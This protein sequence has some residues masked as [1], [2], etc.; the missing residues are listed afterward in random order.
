MKKHLLL[1]LA[2][3]ALLATACKTKNTP[4][5]LK[6]DVP[7][8]P[9][10]QEN[11][12]GL[13]TEPLDTV[14]IGIVGLGMRGSGAV[15]RLTYVPG[16]VITALCDVVP[17]R[18]AK[19]QEI[20]ARRGQPAAKEYTGEEAAYQAL[21]QQEDL[22]LVYICTDWSHHVPVALCAM[23]NGKHADIEVPAAGTLED[24]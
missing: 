4:T 3:T 8:R 24:I 10:G 23:E 2:V 19:S 14:R 17:E 1:F 21:C 6:T 12:I 9:A 15:E 5:V 18:V 7:A 16:A 22:D 20:L 11:V 13:R